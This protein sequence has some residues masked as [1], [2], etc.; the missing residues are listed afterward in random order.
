MHLHHCKDKK[1][2][3]IIPKIKSPVFGGQKPVKANEL[4]WQQVVHCMFS[5]KGVVHL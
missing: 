1:T 5:G 3:I 2:H 4:H